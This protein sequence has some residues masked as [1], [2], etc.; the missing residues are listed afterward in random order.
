MTCYLVYN[1][2]CFIYRFFVYAFLDDCFHC[3]YALIFMNIKKCNIISQCS[4]PSVRQWQGCDRTFL[5][6]QENQ[7]FERYLNSFVEP[8]KKLTERGIYYFVFV[9]LNL[10]YVTFSTTPRSPHHDGPRFVK[11]EPRIS[12]MAETIMY[13]SYNDTLF[14]C[15][16]SRLIHVDNQRLNCSS[17]SK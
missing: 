11:Y 16:I 6:R 4:S 10:R 2:M 14:Q 17:H 15:I 8:L 13:L 3:K 1:T 12:A 7:K 5:E 9:L